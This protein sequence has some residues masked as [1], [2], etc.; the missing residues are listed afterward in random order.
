LRKHQGNAPVRTRPRHRADLR[1]LPTG[2]RPGFGRSRALS[3]LP[4]PCGLADFAQIG[5]LSMRSRVGNREFSRWPAFRNTWPTDGCQGFAAWNDLRPS[6][7][8]ATEGPRGGPS[9]ARGNPLAALLEP[10]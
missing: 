7:S 5:E 3:P 6:A 9:A 8:W 10:G 4:G 1:L 2:G